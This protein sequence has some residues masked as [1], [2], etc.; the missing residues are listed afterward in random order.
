[1]DLQC[2]DDVRKIID[3][4]TKEYVF[5]EKY[6][7][8]D[9]GKGLIK[10]ANALDK[11]IMVIAPENYG[12]RL[13]VYSYGGC[14]ATIS[15]KNGKVNISHNKN[16]KPSPPDKENNVELADYVRNNTL[17]DYGK[18]L[19]D[20]YTDG[21]GSEYWS[22]EGIR[23]EYTRQDRLGAYKKY[24]ELLLGNNSDNLIVDKTFLDLCVY[25]TYAKGFNL[26]KNKNGKKAESGEVK[27][28]GQA[29]P[30]YAGERE[31]QCII[32]KN[33]MMQDKYD[34]KARSMVVV[35]VEYHFV[36]EGT[37]KARV[38]FVV[39]DGE[40]FG[41]VEFKYLGKS[42][43]DSKNSISKHYRDFN[44]A[45]GV[46]ANRTAILKELIWKTRL[47]CDYGILDNSWNTAIEEFE[48]TFNLKK[49]LQKQLWCGFYFLGS[50]KDIKDNSSNS[51]PIEQIR[52]QI[53]DAQYKQG[54]KLKCKMS[55][56]SKNGEIDRISTGW[57]DI[58]DIDEYL[59]KQ[60]NSS[61]IID[62]KQRY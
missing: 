11:P 42:M 6:M 34:L 51:N 43:T 27:K 36:G 4:L 31:M 55:E 37:Q 22:S 10:D 60:K 12:N 29:A 17:Y 49:D 8:K 52:K 23:K 2:N 16:G 41:L 21:Q 19:Y 30:Q 25:S 46:D 15:L 61:T 45:M 38:D 58:V 7:Y 54:V 14:I 57:E 20:G 50:G 5:S 44:K 56:A 62:S 32:A 26:K 47:L 39:F 59:E 1:M 35:D 3:Y 24:C 9:D 48:K 18:F 40:S 28:L 33:S 53:D 13:R